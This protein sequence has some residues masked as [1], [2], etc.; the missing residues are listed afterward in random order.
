MYR[1]YLCQFPTYDIEIEL[2]SSL[3]LGGTEL[4]GTWVFSIISVNH[5]SIY[6][7]K[8]LFFRLKKKRKYTS[9]QNSGYH[10]TMTI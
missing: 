4:E 10:K 2:C 8:T 1:G 3:A 6:I 7:T 5:M 9:G